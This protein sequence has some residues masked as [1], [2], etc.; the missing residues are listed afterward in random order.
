M[1]IRYPIMTK[2][3]E[4]KSIVVRDGVF[5]P[6]NCMELEVPYIEDQRFQD[7]SIGNVLRFQ[8]SKNMMGFEKACVAALLEILKMTE[9]G[10]RLPAHGK[11]RIARI[12][13]EALGASR[14]IPKGK[15]G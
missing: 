1:E 2:G 9:Y 12:C 11:P 5:D 13:R 15:K 14:V 3:M 6:E 7:S 4:V 8:V 10:V